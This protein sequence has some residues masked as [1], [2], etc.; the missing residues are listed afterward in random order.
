MNK[1]KKPFIGLHIL[2]E[3]QTKEIKK[4]KSLS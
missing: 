3:I 2:G 4:L 1:N